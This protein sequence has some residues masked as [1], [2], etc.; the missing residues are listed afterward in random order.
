MAHKW[1]DATSYSQSDKERVPQTW[2]LRLNTLRVI[3]TRHI[4][5][6]P[7]EWVL[8]CPELGVDQHMLRSKDL[9]KAKD[10]ALHFIHAK[11]KRFIN[12]I[13]EAQSGRDS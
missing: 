8:S 4:W 7:D 1:K 13:K 12:D 6:K 3:I 11:V 9:E 5:F 2:E 10:E